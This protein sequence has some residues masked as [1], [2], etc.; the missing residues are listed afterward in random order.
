MRDF[1]TVQI[2]TKL[3]SSLANKLE[4]LN[5][6]NLPVSVSNS[7]TRKGEAIPSI[8]EEQKKNTRK[9]IIVIVVVVILMAGVAYFATRKKA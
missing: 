3:T 6:S 4:S 1:S 7:E 9:T 8:E 5:A 2:N